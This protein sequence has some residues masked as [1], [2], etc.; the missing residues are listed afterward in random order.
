ME[1]VF[2]KFNQFFVYKPW[3]SCKVQAYYPIL[4][5]I[6][7]SSQTRGMP[8]GYGKLLTMLKMKNKYYWSPWK[9]WA[10]HNT[11]GGAS[12]GIISD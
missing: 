7:F 1:K 11:L 12:I 4:Q 2:D 10:L 6:F 9:P 3:I 5:N 8:W